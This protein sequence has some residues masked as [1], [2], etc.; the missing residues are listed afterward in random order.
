[1]GWPVKATARARALHLVA[2]PSDRAPDT[3]ALVRVAAGDLGALGEVYDRHASAV[4]RFAA[5]AAGPHDAEDVVQATFIKAAR[6]ASTYDGRGDSA[7]SWLFGIAARQIQGRR[8]SLARFARA[9]ARLAETT[10]SSVT[11]EHI[12]RSDLE[13]GLDSLSDAKRIVIVLA[14]VEGYTCEELARMLSIPVGTVWTR[15]HHARKELRAF[16]ERRV[17]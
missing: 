3:E 6:I 8:R 2:P 11:A 10:S 17:P 16:Y 12:P 4:L 13:R 5:R 1:V 7:R 9:L 15:L 14:E